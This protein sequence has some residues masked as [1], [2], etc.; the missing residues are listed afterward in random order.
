MSGGGGSSSLGPDVWKDLL[1]WYVYIRASLH[2]AGMD[3]EK[4][5]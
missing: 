1:N 5:V 4:E 3:L 2:V